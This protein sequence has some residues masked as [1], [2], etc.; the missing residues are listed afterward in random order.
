MGTP[1]LPVAFGTLLMVIW[2]GTPF[3]WGCMHLTKGITA[4]R[5]L[6]DQDQCGA[7]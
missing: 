3:Y 2:L 6:V 1:M 5:R 4:R 7:R